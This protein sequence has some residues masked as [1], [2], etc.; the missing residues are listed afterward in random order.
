M[1]IFLRTITTMLHAVCDVVG[2]GIFDLI[3]TEYFFVQKRWTTSF[4]YI[5]VRCFQSINAPE[6]KTQVHNC[7][8]YVVN[9]SYVWLLLWNSWME[10]NETWQEA[11][12]RRSLPSL[13]FSGQSEKQD[14]S[15]GLGLGETFST[16][17]LQLL[18]KIW[19]NLTG[20]KIS[21]S[22]TKFVFSS[23]LDNRKP[24]M[25]DMASD[26]PRHFSVS[27]ETA[28]WNSMRLD[29]RQVLNILY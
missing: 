19:R 25:T 29:R 18:N 1:Y 5:L 8:L 4:S 13:C 11:R 16:C 14:G 27:P 23:L 17:F 24:N 26:W 22:S 3:F 20:S 15:P 6:P 21:T 7:A 2:K 12:T 28:E 9:F 10:F